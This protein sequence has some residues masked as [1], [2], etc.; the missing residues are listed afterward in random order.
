VVL[1][2]KPTKVLPPVMLMAAPEILRAASERRK[3]HSSFTPAGQAEHAEER[4]EA[5]AV[6]RRDP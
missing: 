4:A 3:T 2:S 5:S 1:K 6:P